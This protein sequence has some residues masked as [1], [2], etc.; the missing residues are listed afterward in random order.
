MT[1]SITL[2]GPDDHARVVG[3]MER[4]ITEMGQVWDP[5]TRDRAL[6]P[7]LDGSPHGAIWLIGPVRAPLGY[8][9]VSFG[10][11]VT[12]GGSEGWVDEVFIRPSVRRRGIGTEVLHSIAVALSKGGVKALHVRVPHDADVTQRFCERVGFTLQPNTRLMSDIF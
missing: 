10:W 8:V 12:L 2:A 6:G 9:L 5:I 7:L 11:S 1:T 4:N 3:L